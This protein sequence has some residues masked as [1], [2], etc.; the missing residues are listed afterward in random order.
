MTN[1]P[2]A[3]TAKEIKEI[4]SLKQL[5]EMWGAEDSA[6]MELRLKEIYTVKF[7]YINESPGYVGDLFIIQSG[8]LGSEYP[9]TRLIRNRKK[10]LEVLE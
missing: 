7:D 5:Q 1:K 10:Q 6:D 3:L 9:V 8:V 4:A 2:M